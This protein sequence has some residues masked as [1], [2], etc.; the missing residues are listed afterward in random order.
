MLRMAPILFANGTKENGSRFITVITVTKRVRENSKQ[1]SEHGNYLKE[2][3]FSRICI[4]VSWN[5]SMEVLCCV[6]CLTFILYCYELKQKFLIKSNHVPHFNLYLTFKSVLLF[7]NGFLFCCF[8]QVYATLIFSIAIPIWFMLMNV[9][10]MHRV[11]S[12]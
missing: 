3:N 11:C 2:N 5:L 10:R 1:L 8:Y 12:F 4:F 9:I 7:S 6:C